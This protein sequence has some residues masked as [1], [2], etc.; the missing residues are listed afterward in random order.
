MERLHASASE[1]PPDRLFR[2]AQR[3]IDDRM[4]RG[5]PTLD[6]H[7]RKSAED[8]FHVAYV[9][10]ASSRPVRISHTDGHPLD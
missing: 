4:R 10:D 8:Y 5:V 9:I 2:G 1:T 7:T 3:Q 6:H